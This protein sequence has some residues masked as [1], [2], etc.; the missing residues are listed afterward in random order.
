MPFE[1]SVFGGNGG[2]PRKAVRFSIRDELILVLDATR[3]LEKKAR[4]LLSAVAQKFTWQSAVAEAGS[5]YP[6]SI[7]AKVWVNGERAC[8][9]RDDDGSAIPM[10][11][12]P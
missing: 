11:G 7:K 10:P 2:E 1:P 12:Q 3:I 6:A 5:A 8:A 4:D 9:V